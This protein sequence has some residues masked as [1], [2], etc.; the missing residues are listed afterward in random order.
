MKSRGTYLERNPPSAPRLQTPLAINTHGTRPVLA[1]LFVTDR[2]PLVV[3]CD[4]GADLDLELQLQVHSCNRLLAR[5]AV[6][7]SN[8]DYRFLYRPPFSHGDLIRETKPLTERS[9]RGLKSV[10]DWQ[11]LHRTRNGSESLNLS[12][13]DICESRDKKS[14]S[15]EVVKVR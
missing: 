7:S 15:S 3:L 11:D 14:F 13:S 9:C 4:V 2:P 6:G 8:F 1:C 5:Q 10:T 12:A